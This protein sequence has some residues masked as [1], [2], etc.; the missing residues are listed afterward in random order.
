[1][2][3]SRVTTAALVASIACAGSASAANP[4]AGTYRGIAPQTDLRVD[5]QRHHHSARVSSAELR[6]TLA[7][8]DGTLITRSTALG[9]AKVSRAGRFKIAESSGGS[10]GPHGLIRLTVRM[11]GRFTSARRAEG[12]FTAAA[13]VTDSPISPAVACSS[14]VVAWNSAR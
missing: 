7:C 14:G 2:N 8:E 13:T 5:V 11:S 9:S 10:Y 6:Y 3:L 4:H 1:M 12:T